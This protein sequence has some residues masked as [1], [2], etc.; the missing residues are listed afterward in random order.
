MPSVN[1]PIDL[2]P[3]QA[4]AANVSAPGLVAETA[5][6]QITTA[7]STAA[8]CTAVRSMWAPLTATV[9]EDEATRRGLNTGGG[10]RIAN[11]Y[12]RQTEAVTTLVTIDD[13]NRQA[14]TLLPTGTRP[15]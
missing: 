9:A 3:A 10:R 7:A 13:D 14:L 2:K 8:A 4:Q 5:A 12:Q 6:Q 11:I 1:K 15:G